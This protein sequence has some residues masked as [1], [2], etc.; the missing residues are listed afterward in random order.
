VA[1]PTAALARA[2]KLLKQLKDRQAPV[3]ERDDYYGGAQPLRFAT[4]EWAEEHAER[5]KG[6]SDNWCG[7]VADSTVERIHVQGFRLDKAATMSDAEAELWR[8]VWLDNDMDAQAAQGILETVVAS[9]SFILVWGDPDTDQPVVTWEHPN[10]VLVE[11]QAENPRKRAAAIR[12][13]VD[14][15]HE[16]LNLY[17]PTEVW[18]WQR[19]RASV[20]GLYVPGGS[21]SDW[22]DREGEVAQ[23]L[24]NPIGDVP[25]VEVMNRPRLALDPM[26][27]IAGTMAMQDAINLLWAYLFNAADYAS[28]PARVIMGQQPPKVPVLDDAGQKIGDREVDPKE[29]TNGR[30]MWLTG[31]H[32]NIGTFP[33]ATL[34]GFSEV[35]EVAVGHLAAQTRTPQ[36]YLIGKMANLSGDALKAA[37]T[38]Q[39]LKSAEFAISNTYPI[40]EVFRLGALVQGN[41]D[42]ATAAQRGT[43]KWK[44]TESRSESQL[45]DAL[46][47]L[48]D[49]GFPFEYLAERYGLDDTELTRVIQM[50]QAEANDPIMA[51]IAAKLTQ[52]SGA[53]APAVSA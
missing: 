21:S 5:Y 12:W 32:A 14:D 16:F 27:D 40:R 10:H 46:Q 25:V 45:A 13:W 34:S 51:S 44:D 31:Q 19:R 42:L 50:R 35:V 39:A 43:V 11:Y 41:K 15:D 33:A 30:L 26:S 6:F 28:M 38:G 52:A 47:K 36:H 24:K 17:L 3:I 20:S 53:A 4:K 1:T 7:V 2:E 9:R 29:L 18:K 49:I 8:S 23:P 48:K 22:E 37:E